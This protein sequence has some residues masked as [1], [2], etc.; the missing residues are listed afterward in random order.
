MTKESA[1]W[2]PHAGFPHTLPLSLSLYSPTGNSG[3]GCTPFKQD[4]PSD[5]ANTE[6]ASVR[7]PVR[8]HPS[9]QICRLLLQYKW[10]TGPKLTPSILVLGRVTCYLITT[11]GIFCH[12]RLQ[13]NMTGGT[14]YQLS[15]VKFHQ[16]TQKGVLV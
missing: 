9:L 3:S 8:R 7:L 2:S 14:L 12:L 10:N 4:S 5:S 15:Y 16:P 1:I 13:Y 11:H 6:D